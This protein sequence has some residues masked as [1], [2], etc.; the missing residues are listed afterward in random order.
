MVVIED[1]VQWRLIF[2]K[3]MKIYYIGKSVSFYLDQ[4]GERNS[5]AKAHLGSHLCMSRM[6]AEKHALEMAKDNGEKCLWCS[7][8]AKPRF[9]NEEQCP[10][11]WLE[12]Y[13]NHSPSVPHN[14]HFKLLM[15]TDCYLTCILF[16]WMF[17]WLSTP[18]S[19]LFVHHMKNRWGSWEGNKAFCMWNNRQTRSTQKKGER[20]VADCNV[21]TLYELPIF[22]PIAMW[23]SRQASS[24][25]LTLRSLKNASCPC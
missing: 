5:K 7:Q 24:I 21:S 16:F 22:I 23:P 17:L 8:M 25:L 10:L 1:S 19:F 11:Q 6:Q 15:T 2:I 3:L 12:L 4:R 9:K 20:T 14:L 13:C 18:I